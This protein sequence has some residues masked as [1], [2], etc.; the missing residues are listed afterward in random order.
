MVS[1]VTVARGFWVDQRAHAAVAR[2]HWRKANASTSRRGTRLVAPVRVVRR[3][4]SAGAVDV[5]CRTSLRVH[6]AAAIRS[7]VLNPWPLWSSAAS[8]GA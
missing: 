3:Y 8:T 4:S 1:V 7:R 6:P 2:D 5:A